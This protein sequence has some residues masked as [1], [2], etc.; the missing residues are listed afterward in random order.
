MPPCHAL[1]RE[2]IA[3]RV[4]VVVLFAPEEPAGRLYR[5][6]QKRP[7]NLYGLFLHLAGKPDRTAADYCGQ[8]QLYQ[9]WVQYIHVTDWPSL[10]PPARSSVSSGTSKLRMSPSL[11]SQ[12]RESVFMEPSPSIYRSIL[13]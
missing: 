7:Q 5:S 2:R 12:S 9:T 8:P 4:A 11:S 1:A 13:Q 3:D 6:K 10:L